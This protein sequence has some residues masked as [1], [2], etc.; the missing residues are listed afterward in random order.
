MQKYIIQVSVES[1]VD[2][3]SASANLSLAIPIHT[4]D[5]M[6]RDGQYLL[7]AGLEVHIYMRGYFPVQGQFQGVE[8]EEDVGNLDISQIMTYPYYHVF[9]GVVT[10]VDVSKQGGLQSYTVQCN[11]MMYF[12]QYHNV[13]QNASAF[14]PR[15]ANSKLKSNLVG[16]QFTGW[17]PYSIIYTLFHDVAGAAGGVGFAIDQKTNVDANSSVG[18]Q[19]LFSLNLEYWKRRFQTRMIHLRMHGASGQVYSAAQGIFL[20]RLSGSRV[21]SILTH[22]KATRSASETLKFD[23]FSAS[24]ALGLTKTTKHPTTGET[25]VKATFGSNVSGTSAEIE[26]VDSNSATDINVFDLEPYAQKLGELGQ[27]NFWESTYQSKLDVA[28]Q[29]C[30]TTGYEFYQDVDGDFVFKPPLYNLDTSSS[31]V[32]RIEEIDVISIAEHDKEPVCTYMTFTG[33]QFRNYQI[34]GLEG[35]WGTRGQ[36]VDYRLVAQFGWRPESFEST[37]HNNP[38][39][40][41]Y[42]AMNRMDILNA[43]TRSAEISILLRP[44]L[45]PGFPVYV[46]GIDCFYYLQNM[47]HSWSFG[48]SC[49][50]SLNLVAKRP[51]FYA[52][53]YSKKRGIGAIDLS[54]MYL[55]KKPLKIIDKEGHPRLSG[56]PNVVLAL[57]PYGVNPLHFVTGA[58][59]KDL[60]NPLVVRNLIKIALETNLIYVDYN[61]SGT[62]EKGPFLMKIDPT[63]EVKPDPLGTEAKEG[64]VNTDAASNGVPEGFQRLNFETFAAGANLLAAAREQRASVAQTYEKVI[65]EITSNLQNLIEKRK[66]LNAQKKNTE[67]INNKISSVERQIESLRNQVTQAESAIQDKYKN[68]EQIQGILDLFK[69][70]MLGY[71]QDQSD[72]PAPN[73]TASYLD[74]LSDKKAAFTNTELPGAYQYFSCSH[75]DPKFQGPGILRA[76]LKAGALVE[77]PARVREQYRDTVGFVPTPTRGPDGVFPEAE[78]GKITVYNGL[79]LLTSQKESFVDKDGKEKT[80]RIPDILPTSEIKSMVFTTHQL[81]L[82]QAQTAYNFGENFTGLGEGTFEVVNKAINTK[83]KK[84]G[85]SLEYFY[86]EDWEKFIKGTVGWPEFYEKVEFPTEVVFLGSPYATDQEDILIDLRLTPSFSESSTDKEITEVLRTFFVNLL[87]VTV[88]TA[89]REKWIELKQEV[90]AGTVGEQSNLVTATTQIE[91]DFKG[92]GKALFGKSFKMKSDKVEKVVGKGKK[93]FASPVFPVSDRKGYEVIGSYQYGRDIDIAP[94]SSY[95]QLALKDPLSFANPS[96]VEEFIKILT[97]DARDTSTGDDEELVTPI[98]KAAAEIEQKLMSGILNNPGT[99]NEVLELVRG[100]MDESKGKKTSV[101]FANWIAASNDQDFKLSV[102]NAAYQLAD[103]QL[104]VNKPICNCRATEADILLSEAFNSENFTQIVHTE[105][106]DQVT[107]AISNLV[108]QKSVGWDKSQKAMG[109]QTTNL[110]PSTTSELNKRK[111]DVSTAFGDLKKLADHVVSD[112]GLEEAIAAFDAAKEKV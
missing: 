22:F 75:P 81:D 82:S 79:A 23:I 69:N 52:P 3:G 54:Q 63:S 94:G 12:W 8:L 103:L 74:L 48:G 37:Y 93:I 35:E 76:D 62:P 49:T 106:L 24:R 73:S 13:S 58:D 104:H 56:F 27:V 51:K 10:G 64:E 109:G 47:S 60:S 107:G 45:R 78:L 50:T 21:Q 112:S 41:F 66:K 44:E 14:G 86:K 110:F 61:N 80:R 96:D 91:A 102:N 100:F 46:V 111:Q 99:P 26:G 6:G 28:Q 68:D 18:D 16:H 5:G 83:A 25:I 84:G 30:Q 34:G 29:V 70:L 65:L 36:Y 55:P 2:A 15:P 101:G 72:Y 20:G 57:N 1:G 4:A 53:G 43:P 11:S 42:A 17:T 33:G 85:T 88:N 38:R 9:H 40:M 89:L 92:I 59:L 95:D 31:R 98:Q 67:A 19:S 108:N 87:Y 7:R 90:L 32:Y 71:I 77:P 97:G 39:T 105:D